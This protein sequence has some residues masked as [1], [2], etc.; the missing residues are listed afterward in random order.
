M[1]FNYNDLCASYNSYLFSINNITNYNSNYISNYNNNNI[2]GSSGLS[3]NYQSSSNSS[4]PSCSSPSYS[5]S[6]SSSG[7]LSY[8]FN[9]HRSLSG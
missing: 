9:G 3:K 2:I 4:S 8:G 5:S 1:S 7:S 6:N